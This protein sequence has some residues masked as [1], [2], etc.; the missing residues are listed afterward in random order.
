[1][2][3]LFVKGSPENLAR[4]EGQNLALANLNLVTRL[5]ISSPPGL[6][7]LYGKIPKAGNLDFLPLGQIFLNDIKYR[8]NY[9]R[10]IFL[11]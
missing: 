10:G 5:G 2:K 6:F 8:L 11:R 4:F 7:F 3:S 9:L 1:M